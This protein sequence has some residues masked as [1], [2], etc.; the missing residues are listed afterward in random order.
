MEYDPAIE[1]VDVLN[2]FD[3]RLVQLRKGYRFSVDALLLCR[4]AG[5]SEGRI[6]D[7][8]TG[9]GVMALIMAR[10]SP[11]ARVVGIEF[12]EETARLA[13]RNVVCNGLSGQV[14]I[15]P[16]DVLGLKGR[17]PV[18]SFDLVLANPP[19]RRRGT[20]RISPHAGRDT[21]RHESTA[22][23]HDF[24]AAAKY[25]V[26][27]A[28]RICFIYHVSRLPDVF[29]EAERLKLAPLRLQ[30]VHGSAGGE[31]RMILLELAKGRIGE[32]KVLPPLIVDA[33]ACAVA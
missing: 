17:F 29:V 11:D 33:D 24:L 28:G 23:L 12:R 15:I 6:A 30:F 18:S 31:A 25:L 1:T 32:V 8:G 27:P 26:K 5:S 7:L 14:T 13:E 3:L 16:A 22:G 20:G 2:S 21:A 9:S 4:F 10:K 19:F